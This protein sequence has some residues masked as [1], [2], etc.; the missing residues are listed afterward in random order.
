MIF[1]QLM[2]LLPR[3]RFGTLV[4]RFGGDHKVRSF[5]CFDQLLTMIF[6][7]LTFCESLRD[8]EA[9][10]SAE[11]VHLYH[12]GIRGRVRRSTLRD[13]NET[14]DARIF[15]GLARILMDQARQLHVDQPLAIDLQAMVYALD[16]TVITLCLKLFPWA[17]FRRTSASIKLHTLLDLHGNIPTFIHVSKAKMADKQI[18]DQLILEAGAFYL[19]DRGYIDFKRLYRFTQ[20]MAFFVM[21]PMGNMRYRVTQSVQGDAGTGVLSDRIIRLTGIFT[22]DHY[23][24]PLRMVRYCDP[25]TLATYDFLTN[26]IELPALLIAQL[27]RQRWQIELFFKWIKQH[28][29]IKAF[30]GTSD[31]A[32]RVQVWTAVAT[33]CLLAIAR[34][35]FGLPHDLHQMTQIL[36]LRLFAK[37]PLLTLFSHTPLTTSSD[38]EHNQLSLFE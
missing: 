20:Q 2:D 34:K 17:Q 4:S 24:S 36:R 5:S 15:E 9:C 35:R 1:S 11:P 3:K 33:Y 37:I 32:V 21:R 18:L 14:R 27:Y 16:A 31:N 38:A 25:E 23:P 13:A 10:L 28:L 22:V 12:L 7:Q 29:R 6:A 26:N 19:M 30:Y 8:I